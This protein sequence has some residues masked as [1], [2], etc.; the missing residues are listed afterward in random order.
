MHAYGA[1]LENL[2]FNLNTRH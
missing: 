2:F 1:S